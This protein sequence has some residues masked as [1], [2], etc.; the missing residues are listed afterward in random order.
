M[1]FWPSCHGQAHLA[2]DQVAQGSSCSG[3]KLLQG[4]EIQNFSGQPL[5]INLTS[6]KNF[7]LISSLNPPYIALKPIALSLY[8]LVK[9]PFSSPVGSLSAKNSLWRLPSPSHKD[10]VLRTWSSLEASTNRIVRST[11]RV[12]SPQGNFQEV[13]K[14]THQSDKKINDW[15]S[16]HSCKKSGH[17][18]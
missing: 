4:C 3:L 6:A 16:N 13:W 15:D 9:H 1:Y 12:Q 2:Q 18:A 17:Y 11:L 10:F 8:L 14:R 5:I 7:F